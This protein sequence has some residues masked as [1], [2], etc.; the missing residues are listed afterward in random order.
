MPIGFLSDAER[1][2][3]RR[4]PG[5]VSDADVA[6]Y[7]TL[8]PADLDLVRRRTGDHNRL[9]FALL[10]C[11]IRYLGFAPVDMS[12]VPSPVVGYVARQ[13]RVAPQMLM[14]YGARDRTR[15]MQI[16]AVLE[17]L[18]MR[19]P[20][21]VDWREL[22]G[23]LLDRAL[24]H[25]KP[26][27]LLGLV[28]E[29]LF[30]AKILRPGITILERVVS[31]ARD[32]AQFETYTRLESLLT[33]EH[34]EKLDGLLRND[35]VLGRT[36]L[37]WLRKGATRNSGGSI[38]DA[39]AKREYLAEHGFAGLDLDAIPPN[40]VKFLAQIARKSTAQ[41]IERMSPV[42]R[43]PVLLAF[44]VQT[45]ID[46]LDEIVDL[47]DRCLA[48]SYGE[49]GRELALIRKRGARSSNEKVVL[50]QEVGSILLDPTIADDE[51]R[52]RVFDLV[53]P[54]TLEEVVH[55]CARIARPLD[56]HYFD[57]LAKKYSYFRTFAPAFLDALDFRS[58]QSAA[59][60]L[61]AVRVLRALN[62]TGR[63]R[64]PKDAPMDFIAAKWR[65]YLF[66][67][68]GKTVRRYYELCVLWELRAAIRSGDVWLEGSRRHAD[69]S[70]YLITSS[71]WRELRPETCTMLHLPADG[72]ERLAVR[73]EELEGLLGRLDR[74][75]PKGGFDIEDG[76]LHVPRLR[77][78]DVPPEVAALEQM[79]SERLPQIDL[80]ELLI[81]VDGWTNF[82]GCFE[83]AGGA[84]PR[85]RD[86]RTYLFAGVVSQACNFGP[87]TMAKV[88]DLVVG[89]LGWCTTWYLREETLRAAMVAV[90]NFQHHLPLARIW[91]GGTLS[92]SDGQRFPVSVKSRHATAIPR[93][94]GYGRGVTSY[95]WTSDQ[96]SQ[97]GTK[98]IPSTT[99]D[100]LYVLDE[101]LDNETELEILEH[102]T[103]TAGYTEIVFALFDLLGLVF[104]PRIRDLGDQQ[105]YRMSR[106]VRYLHLEPLLKGT[107]RKD[108]LLEMWDELLRVAGSLKLGWVT[109]SLLVGKLQ[110][111]PRQNA[112]SRALQ[113]YGRLVKT[114]FI[115]RYIDSEDYRRRIGTQINKGEVLHALRNYLFFANEGKVRRRHQEEQANQASC[116]NLVVNAIV[117]WNT[118]YMNEVISRLRREG[119]AVNDADVA[120]LSPA[121][122]GHI[123]P[124]GKYRFD[125]DAA[126]DPTVL[127]PL[128][129]PEDR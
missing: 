58:A 70:S 43:Y 20:T 35:T 27:L 44:A 66:D 14:S 126:L 112:L 1:E 76:S 49:A 19:R 45:G 12:A 5:T 2:R 15:H 97:Y 55:D 21:G 16:R 61:D 7:F 6:G 13:L 22:S 73:R 34:R 104:S 56:D 119:I 129:D 110:S 86:L 47:Y 57:L 85:T 68:K 127:R 37:V 101:I 50:L 30:A 122:Y 67:G 115:L 46:V 83:H 96:F 72:R 78:V 40:R 25:D 38:L 18:G 8:S 23:W 125:I 10:L 90:V 48:H 53:A 113:E 106:E 69:P 84:E 11:A 103:D 95:T 64:V 26:T 123:N 24:E 94:F 92:S 80:S 29:R 124:Y 63:R 87:V 91:G 98:V 75:F 74:E 79:V 116:L 42:R 60:L 39:I 81:E 109:A 114:V 118:V 52:P 54:E 36:P 62:A 4:F 89:R 107:I 100:A 108:R 99:R 65:P 71:Q 88:A 51:V 93:Y 102:A 28:C 128:R 111:Y 41:A 33:D 77:A 31:H 17:H 117:T 121:R 3:L 32:Q 9:G 82:T 105:L 120:H 59:S